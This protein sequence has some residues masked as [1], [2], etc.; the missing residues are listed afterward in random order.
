MIS[1]SDRVAPP[2]WMGPSWTQ[3][4]KEE[5]WFE[6]EWGASEAGDLRLRLQLCLQQVGDLGS[7]KA[8]CTDLQLSVL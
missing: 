8:D 5:E 2:V 4:I 6:R 3:R 1:K 7:V